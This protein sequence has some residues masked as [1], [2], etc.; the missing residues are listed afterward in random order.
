MAEPRKRAQTRKATT[1]IA[2]FK[3]VQQGVD[4]G[5]RKQGDGWR[6]SRGC[7]GVSVIFLARKPS[8]GKPGTEGCLIW[9]L[10]WK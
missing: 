9:E 8:T 4:P 6:Y 2:E 1:G 3:G 7:A 10:D 5:I